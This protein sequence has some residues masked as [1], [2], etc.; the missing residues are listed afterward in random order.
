MPNIN[1]AAKRARQA[2]RARQRNQKEK[3]RISS[4]RRSVLEAAAGGD[5][6]KAEKACR[7]Y[8]SFVDRAVKSGVLTRNA[9]ARRKSRAAARVAAL[10]AA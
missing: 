9:A 10:S 8:F 7:E 1:S 5:K 4:A 3:S 2:E 6:A